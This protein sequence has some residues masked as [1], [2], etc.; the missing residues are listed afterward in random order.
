MYS[1]VT[2]LAVTCGCVIY[3]PTRNGGGGGS[4]TVR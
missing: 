1:C 2:C 3:D 4:G